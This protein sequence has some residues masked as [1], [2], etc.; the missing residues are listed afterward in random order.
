M[1]GG[2]GLASG[3]PTEVPRC[4]GRDAPVLY[5][6]FRPYPADWLIELV[7]S[8][9]SAIQFPTRGLAL[10]QCRKIFVQKVEGNRVNPLLNHSTGRNVMKIRIAILALL[11]IVAVVSSIYTIK[12]MR[13]WNSASRWD[14]SVWLDMTQTQAGIDLAASGKPIPQTSFNVLGG[15]AVTEE[16]YWSEEEIRHAEDRVEELKK[17]L[18][19]LGEDVSQKR[20]KFIVKAIFAVLFCLSTIVYGTSVFIHWRRSLQRSTGPSKANPKLNA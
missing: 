17:I 14:A 4:K 16:R 12:A 20:K 10:C 18:P 15:Q 9:S 19:Q 1:R 11:C 6:I 8:D 3:T 5:R 7:V 13:S 2:A